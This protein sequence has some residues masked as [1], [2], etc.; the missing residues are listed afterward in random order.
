MTLRQL[1]VFVCVAQTGSFSDAASIL[2]F[3]QPTISAHITALEEE[4]NVELF[5]RSTKSVQITNEG[6]QLLKYATK[7]IDIKNAIKRDIAK[8]SK[9]KEIITIAASTVPAQYILPDILSLFSRTYPDIKFEVIEGPSSEVADIILNKKADIGFVGS[10]VDKRRI[11]CIPFYRDRL[12]ILTPNTK[13]YSSL[14]GKMPKKIIKNTPVI[15]RSRGS[16][17]RIEVENHLESIG[18]RLEDLH[19]V[20]AYDNPE[21]VKKSVIKGMG[22]TFASDTIAREEIKDKKILSFPFGSKPIYRDIS[23]IY[24]NKKQNTLQEKLLIQFVKDYYKKD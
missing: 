13:T 2:Y 18:I 11:K 14:N 21:I 6:K 23:L 20:A 24:L 4:L 10:K 16:G 3:T 9:S 19:V 8:T 22:I 17:T 5:K 7:M 1:E 15:M 12:V